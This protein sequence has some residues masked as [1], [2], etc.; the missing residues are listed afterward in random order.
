MRRRHGRGDC[1][2]QGGTV[3]SAN[4]C[5]GGRRVG[6]GTGALFCL[7]PFP[8]LRRHFFLGGVLLLEVIV[9]CLWKYDSVFRSADD[10]LCLGRHERT[11][12][13]C[14][15]G[16]TMGRA[17]CGYSGWFCCLDEEPTHQFKFVRPD[18]VF[19]R[20]AAF[21]SASVSMFESMAMLKALSLLL[22]F[23]YCASALESPLWAGATF[24]P[25][26]ALGK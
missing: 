25:R 9:A 19:L 12:A 4:R 18:C 13:G 26:P 10:H 15:D 16:R 22:L 20:C 7:S 17:G 1:R 14:L 2:R 23:L 3:S 11:S 6:L 24:F 8:E 5:S 21:V